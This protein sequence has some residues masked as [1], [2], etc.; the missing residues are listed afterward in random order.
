[1]EKLEFV[2]SHVHY[3]DM[4][5]P[6]LTYA[7]WAPGVNHATLGTQMAKLGERNFIAE[8]YI[9]LTRDMNV[10]KAIHVQAAIGSRDPVKETEWLQEAADRTGF[11]HGIVAF[12]DLSDPNVEKTLE[13]HC[14]FPNMRGIRDFEGADHLT[15]SNLLNG[16]GLMEKYDLIPS[17]NVTWHHMDSV[18]SMAS[19]FSNTQIVIDHTGAPRERGAE[20]IENW[21][22][23]M[24]TVAEA[25]NVWCKISGL[26]MT[27]PDWT[28]ES[29][30]PFVMYCIEIFGVDKCFFGTNWP[31]DSLWGEFDDLVNAYTE[32][33]SSFS[34]D[35]QER[36][37]RRN[38]EELY[39]I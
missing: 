33:I 32:I 39:G 12:A 1:V 11:P 16:F 2:D 10:V 18:R 4:Q 21:K 38:A 30:R 5:H 26:S 23:G 37:F 24:A 27:D 36:L 31:V 19:R 20:Y 7:H 34:R 6:E 17:M 8:D 3:Y 14:E 13:R 15:E 28:I 25:D 35:E 22:R 29:I 9:E